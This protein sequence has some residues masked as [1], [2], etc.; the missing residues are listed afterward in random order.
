MSWLPELS[1]R[2]QRQVLGV[3]LVAFAGLATASLAT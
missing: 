1:E 2:R 3:L